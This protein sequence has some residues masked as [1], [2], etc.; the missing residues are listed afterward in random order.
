[1]IDDLA[2]LCEAHPDS[3]DLAHFTGLMT[4]SAASPAVRA[5][6][7]GLLEPMTSRRAVLLKRQMPTSQ[8]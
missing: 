6:L 2:P 5:R 7:R 4:G 1:V 3:D 8:P